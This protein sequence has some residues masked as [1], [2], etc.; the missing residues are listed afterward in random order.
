MLQQKLPL[1]K[2]ASPSYCV[3]ETACVIDGETLNI[4]GT[5]S[6]STELSLVVKLERDLTPHPE[7]I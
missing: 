3:I 6:A 5:F 2:E 1:G 4:E 7:H